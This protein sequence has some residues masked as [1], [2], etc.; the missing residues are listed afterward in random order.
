MAVIMPTGIF[1]VSKR[2]PRPEVEDEHGVPVPSPAASAVPTA[3]LP[4]AVR[5]VGDGSFTYR[6]DPSTWPV[7]VDDIITSA[8]GERFIVRTVKKNE[9]VAASALDYI[10]GTCVPDV[11]PRR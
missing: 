11:N 9:N 2:V 7:S 4:G 3:P 10:G 8:V 1:R 6:L 5:E